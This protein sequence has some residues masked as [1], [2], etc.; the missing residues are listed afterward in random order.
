MGKELFKVDI[1]ALE[2][3]RA[4]PTMEA[5]GEHWSDALARSMKNTLS[6]ETLRNI[7]IDG[8]KKAIP[9]TMFDG[10]A[11]NIYDMATKAIVEAIDAVD[12]EDDV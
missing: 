2:Q 7:A 8:I 12:G 11:D 3:L 6:N 9:G 1:I 10:F 5:A 4:A